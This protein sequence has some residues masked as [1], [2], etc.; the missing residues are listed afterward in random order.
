MK[1]TSFPEDSIF[2]KIK[3]DYP[4]YQ[5]NLKPII[6]DLFRSNNVTALIMFLKIPYLKDTLASL[7]ISLYALNLI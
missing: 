7:L 2:S 4:K 1:V 3:Q 6:I 5:E